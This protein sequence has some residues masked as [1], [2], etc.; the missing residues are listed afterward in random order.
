MNIRLVE[1]KKIAALLICM[2]CIVG[3]TFAKKDAD[4]WKKEQTLEK[5]YEIF[6]E[7]LNFW[8]GS[9]FLKPDQMEVFYRS[10]T[11]TIDG[12]EKQVK[13]SG[14]KIQ[15]L[16]NQLSENNAQTREIQ[17]KLDVSIKNQESIGVFGVM[18]HKNTYTL[19]M[20][21]IILGLLVLLAFVFLMFKRSHNITSKTKKDY[22][23]LKQEF[24]THRK[25]ALDRY[26]KI[27]ME[28]H[29]T[30]LELKKGSIKS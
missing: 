29:Q 18:L 12:L 14:S 13:E 5:Q 11:D 24:E 8:N 17:E 20:S 7:N 16:Q 23:E 3:V 28:L 27:N 10:L 26:T 15:Q 2:V 6:I 1:M 22:E 25:N 19:I 21:T 4:A 30:R 9:Y